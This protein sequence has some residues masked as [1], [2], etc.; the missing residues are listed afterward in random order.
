MNDG[1]KN[2]SADAVQREYVTWS[3]TNLTKEFSLDHKPLPTLQC[4]ECSGIV[5]Q[6]IQTDD[7]ET[8][9]RCENCGTYYKVHCG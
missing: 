4:R 3:D 7:W 5:F 9:A 8:S 6:V 1:I 2:I